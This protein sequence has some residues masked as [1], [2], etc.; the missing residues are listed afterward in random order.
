MKTILKVCLFFIVSFTIVSCTKVIDLNLEET[1][2][3][4]VIE[5]RIIKD[6]FALVRVTKT[7][8]YL[9]NTPTPTVTNAFIVISNNQGALD[10]LD[11][12]GNGY[13]RGNTIVG[14]TNEIYTLS[15]NA[16]G[17]QHVATTTIL[18]TVTFEVTG[19]VFNDGSG[20]KEE[21]YYPTIKTTLPPDSYYLFYYYKNDTLYRE[22]PSDVEVT[23]S[24]FIGTE[25]DGVETPDPY[26]TGDVAKINIYRITKE[27]FDFY[28][29]LA[30]QLNND[31]GFFS[32]PPAN[33]RSNF[34]NGAVGIFMGASLHSESI[35]ITP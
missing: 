22:N 12:V 34:S 4:T 27:T 26:A 30:L 6:S 13:Y 20:F 18:P 17:Q 5:G 25:L 3:K 29:D 28:N 11:H 2:E 7:A 19:F 9:E 32:T 1:A 14:Q 21:G 16:D 10:T 33:T 31:G 23:D 15:V 35:T 24:K 8:K